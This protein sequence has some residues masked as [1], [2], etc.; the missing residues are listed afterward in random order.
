LGFVLL[1]VGLR[2]NSYDAP[3]T[4]DEGEY[5]YSAWLLKQGIAPYQHAFLQKP[6][7]IVYTYLLAELVA[8]QTSWFPRVLAAM[9]VG[10]TTLL[11]G[12][13]ARREFGT[14]SG[15]MAMYFFTPMVLLPRIE[16]F[17][18]NT[19]M[20]LILPL[21]GTVAIYVFARNQSH[22]WHWLAAGILA[23]LCLLYKLTVL[24]LLLFLGVVWSYEEW[25]TQRSPGALLRRWL[26][27]VAG[28]LLTS[29]AVLAF[30]LKT[31]GGQSLW[32]CVVRFNRYYS[33][34]G[35]FNLAVAGFR[36]DSFWSAWWI[37]FLLP[38]ALIRK[39]SS[40]IWFWLAL[41][42][43]GFVETYG[44]PDGHYYIPAMLF[45]ALLTTAAANALVS[46]VPM[47]F[48]A[49]RPWIKGAIVA[50]LLS[51][52]CLPD[53]PVL[54]LAKER[55]LD[56]RYEFRESTTIAQR[57]AEITS[58]SDYV[59]VAGSEPQILYQAR[60]R[61]CTRFVLVYPLM[62]PTPLAERYQLEAIRDLQQRPPA[63]VVV[64]LSQKSWLVQPSTPKEFQIYLA[65]LLS[66]DYE[67]IGGYVS[68]GG[69]SFWRGAMSGS[70]QHS[71]MLLFRLKSR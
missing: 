21:A 20:F 47:C 23:A 49:S 27:C 63:A 37:L 71:T 9:F 16:Q 40:R 50:I 64:A 54:A 5:A 61:S 70:M 42:V 1:F 66:R 39:S 25:K 48:A 43:L 30:F 24:P 68:E 67:L 33:Q 15:M 19:E 56:R 10:L 28:G 36:F 29:G 60:R 62:I 6:P 51:L 53:A 46:W 41:T 32:D 38:L 58:S 22:G 69:G 26:L 65:G 45:W 13:I 3:L 55:F 44:I 8:P 34:S 4:R 59:L 7:M 31:D 11:I 35:R 2:W 17:T 57:L 52:I 12:A 18:A 14:G